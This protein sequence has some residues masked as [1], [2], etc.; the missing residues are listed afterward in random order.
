M[1]SRE[2][3]ASN[4]VDTV[5]KG[6]MVNKE[7]TD[8]KGDIVNKVMVS[9]DN[10]IIM[11]SNSSQAIPIKDTWIKEE[12]IVVGETN[13]LQAR[14]IHQQ[15]KA[16]IVDGTKASN[17][18]IKEIIADGGNL[19]QTKAIIVVGINHSKTKAITIVDGGIKGPNGDFIWKILAMGSIRYSFWGTNSWSICNS[20][21][22]LSWW[23]DA[24]R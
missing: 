21:H 12:I 13:L 20:E 3:M 7:D 9:K 6:D 24:K 15:T 16:T 4:K 1:G 19:Q 10:K 14:E 11:G 2:D 8:S 18:Q 5:N 23:E 17:N 22:F